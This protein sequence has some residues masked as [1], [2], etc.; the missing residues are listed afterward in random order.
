MKRGKGVRGPAIGISISKGLD[1]MNMKSEMCG[2]ICE[3]DL[4]KSN[5]HCFCWAL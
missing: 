3:D 5:K 2:R 4:K 1:W